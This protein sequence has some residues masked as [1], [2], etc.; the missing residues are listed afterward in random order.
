MRG[1]SK[2]VENHYSRRSTFVMSCCCNIK[3]CNKTYGHRNW[4]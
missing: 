2:K 4:L 1:G 3:T